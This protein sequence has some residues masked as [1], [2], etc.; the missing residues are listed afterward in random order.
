MQADESLAWNLHSGRVTR[1]ST[2]LAGD[3][4]ISPD[5]RFVSA[6]DFGGDVRIWLTSNGKIVRSLHVG[7]AT[8][9]R[10]NPTG[11]IV[12][13][14]PADNR[15]RLW[16][17]HSGK[18]LRTLP[19]AGYGFARS[20]F[21]PTGNLLAVAEWESSSTA[22]GYGWHGYA[23]IWNWHTGKLQHRL[24]AGVGPIVNHPPVFSTNGERLLVISGSAIYVW[25]TKRGTLLARL[26]GRTGAIGAAHFDAFGR[27]VIAVGADSAAHVFD[28][29]TGSEIAVLAD[30]GGRVT[31]ASFSPHDRWLLTTG[32]DGEIHIYLC[33]F[34]RS[35]TPQQGR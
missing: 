6:L 3:A 21:D 9:L 19:A 10:L 11:D 4:V 35:P 8:E 14:D 33:N 22:S 15:L 23:R 2:R 17:W 29:A 26:A 12:A 5:G 1:P 27:Y 24:E 25:Q 28:I 13:T 30:H 32:T 31:D 18:L 34:C 20:A 16:D 7:H